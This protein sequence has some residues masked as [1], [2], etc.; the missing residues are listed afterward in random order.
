MP[1]PFPFRP[2]GCR[3]LPLVVVI[4]DIGVQT[5]RMVPATAAAFVTAG[6]ISV[7]VFPLIAFSRP[8]NKPS[9]RGC[10]RGVGGER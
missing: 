6:L 2:P 8:L 7:L 9:G 4:T 3:S 10:P 5:K 1:V